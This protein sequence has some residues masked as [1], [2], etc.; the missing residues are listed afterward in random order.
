MGV[1]EG[2]C[3]YLC[4][5]GMA[6]GV[7]SARS[8]GAVFGGVPYTTLYLSKLRLTQ[9]WTTRSNAD[10]PVGITYTRIER[11]VLRG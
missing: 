7:S 4:V 3:V 5:R 11:N 1:S 9:M 2:V 8:Y 10:K 6:G